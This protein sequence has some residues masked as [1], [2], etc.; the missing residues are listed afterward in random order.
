MEEKIVEIMR[1][2]L[3]NM[4]GLWPKLSSASGLT[5]HWLRAFA[6]GRIVSPTVRSF[7][8]L[9]RALGYDVELKEK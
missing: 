5:Q 9:A 1:A 4:R 3:L 8:R 7:C 6:N 2:K